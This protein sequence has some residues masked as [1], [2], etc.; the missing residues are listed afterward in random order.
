MLRLKLVRI[1]IIVN[2]RFPVSPDYLLMIYMYPF[3][4]F[5]PAARE[6]CSSLWIMRR[7]LTCSASMVFWACFCCCQIVIANQVAQVADVVFWDGP[8]DVV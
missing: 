2:V 7:G 5:M 6:I 4:I 1:I 3:L 8:V